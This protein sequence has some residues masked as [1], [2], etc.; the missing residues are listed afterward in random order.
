MPIWNVF[1]TDKIV[2]EYGRV[3]IPRKYLDQLNI[4]AMDTV[5][6]YADWD[7]EI[8][9]RKKTTPSH[10]EHVYEQSLDSAGKLLLPK[11]VRHKFDID[12]GTKVL[13]SLYEG[14][15]EVRLRRLGRK[16]A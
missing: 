8:R 7:Q 15:N 14:H 1:N 9:I 13:V 6:I 4:G 3:Y 2:D 11:P 16:R 12:A 10:Q 5:Q